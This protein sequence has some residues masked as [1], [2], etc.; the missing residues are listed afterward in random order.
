MSLFR[1]LMADPVIRARIEA[2]TA[3]SRLMKETGAASGTAGF[4]AKNAKVA[5]K[6]TVKAKAKPAAK[7]KA[8]PK[9][10]SPPK[11]DPHAGMKH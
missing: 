3:L 6:T 1:R 10:K 8:K 2:D 7:A 4:T 9:A 11:T 5:K